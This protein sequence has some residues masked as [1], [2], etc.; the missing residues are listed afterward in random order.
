MTERRGVPPRSAPAF[1]LL[2]SLLP[3]RNVQA[4]C[5]LVLLP[6]FLPAVHLLC[7]LRRNILVPIEPKSKPI[8]ASHVDLVLEPRLISY[9]TFAGINSQFHGF[10]KFAERYNSR[11]IA[12]VLRIRGVLE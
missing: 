6:H 7:L 12:D 1:F 2:R 11:Q 5:P 3:H 4:L 8:Q 10:A 9:L